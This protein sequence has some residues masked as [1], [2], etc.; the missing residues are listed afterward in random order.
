M[1]KFI[2]SLVLA[3]T[4]PMAAAIPMITMTVTD[5]NS[6]VTEIYTD[7]LSPGILA[8]TSFDSPI[9]A[10]YWDTGAIQIGVSDN[11]DPTE[12]AEFITAS[13]NLDAAS[14][15]GTNVGVKLVASE[16]VNPPAGPATFHTI[17]NAATVVD[18]AYS[19]RVFV[20]GNLL[21]QELDVTTTDTF[22]ATNTYVIG[23]PFS[24]EHDFQLTS[25]AEG[26]D[27]GFDI[28]TRAVPTPAPLALM[29]LGLLGMV[30]ARKLA[31]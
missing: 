30:S 21:L 8:V 15:L 12:L 17:I 1:K 31:G 20:D 28:S 23:S 3:L 9:M 19:A 11:Q 16:Y 18:T 27:L 10:S 5:L 29:G 24:I 14:V 22:T 6:L 2:L 25:L 7:V 4:A 26:G 13:I